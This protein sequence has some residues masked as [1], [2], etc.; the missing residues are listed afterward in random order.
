MDSSA[1][2]GTGVAGTCTVTF[3]GS[4]YIIGGYRTNY[5]SY[6]CYK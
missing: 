1:H 3:N 2:D 4:Q 6:Y 5:V